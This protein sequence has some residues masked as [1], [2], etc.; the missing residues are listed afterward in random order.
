MTDPEILEMRYPVVVEEFS[1]R[2]GSGGKGKFGGGAGTT[3]ILRFL[4]DM[5]CAILSSSR[6][7]PPRGLDGGGD[8]EVGSTLI[9]RLSGDLQKLAHCDQTDV[10]QGEAVIVN[11]PGAGGYG[12]KQ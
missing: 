7:H 1:I 12:E 11:T 3:R 8:G 6:I 2:K 5:Q 9:R 4:E 10:H